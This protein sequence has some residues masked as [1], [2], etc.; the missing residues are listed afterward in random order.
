VKALKTTLEIPDD[1]LH[2]AKAKAAERAFLCQFVTEAVEEKI[3]TDP[4][5]T[6]KPW[7]AHAGKLRHLRKDL[8]RIDRIVE[9]EFETVEPEEWT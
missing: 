5:A 6:A 4:T 3:R 1:V 7:M 9:A 8:R 2:R